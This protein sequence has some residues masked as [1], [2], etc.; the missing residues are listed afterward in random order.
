M[1]LATAADAFRRPGA[2]TRQWISYATVDADSES[3]PSVA[4]KDKD[5][6][7]SPYGPLVSVT[8]QPSGVR[9]RCRVAGAV[10]GEQ[11]ADWYPFVGGDEVIV[12]I[13]EGDERAGCVIV[14]RLNQELDLFPLVV[15][16]QDSSK[17]VFGFRRMRT[18]FVVETAASYLIR[19]ALTG[20]Q[21]GIDQEGKVIVNDG[22]RGSLT[23]GPESLGLASGDGESFVTIF[24][25]DQQV[26]LGAGSA[27]FLLDAAESKFISQGL[28]SFATNGAS[29]NQFGVTAEQVVAFVIN[30]LAQLAFSGSFSAGPLASAAYS[31]NSVTQLAAVVGP[32]LQALATPTPF[33]P[34]GSPSPPSGSFALFLASAPPIFGP[35]GAL[36]AAMS[37]PL[38]PIDPTGTIF[39]FGRSGFKL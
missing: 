6:N 3:N 15:A 19:S 32:A 36:T 7:P 5:G 11:E 26:Y 30:V 2:D 22:D 29:P 37:N 34:P 8:L 13:P 39:G 35:T 25:P 14:G 12:L 24:P 9:V 1:D 18:P 4:F 28:L 17:N 27:T 23:I 10:A 21:I 31:L 20:S 38:A 16:G 33:L